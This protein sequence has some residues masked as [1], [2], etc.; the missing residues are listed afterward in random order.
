MCVLPKGFEYLG[1][2]VS[3]KGSCSYFSYCSPLYQLL[4][5]NSQW[6]WNTKQQEDFTA[7]KKLLCEDGLLVH[8]NVKKPLKLFCDTLAYGVGACLVHVMPNGH[9][10]CFVHFDNC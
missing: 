4:Q 8:F 10:M 7:V 1:H 5:K 3:I 6:A 9:S 2:Q